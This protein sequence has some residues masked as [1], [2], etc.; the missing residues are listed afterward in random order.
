MNKLAFHRERYG[1]KFVF[2]QLSRSRIVPCLRMIQDEQ[3]R[4]GRRLTLLDVGCGDGSVSRLLLK[5]GHRVLGVDLVP[6]FVER[7]IEKGIE[8]KVA[9]VSKDGLPFPEGEIVS[10][11]PER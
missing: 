11:T 1:D 5:A 8:A 2:D 4:R 10:Y 6:E 9:D 3:R 7:A